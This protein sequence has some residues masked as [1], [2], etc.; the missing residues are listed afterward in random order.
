MYCI[1]KAAR[2]IQKQRSPDKRVHVIFFF[3]LRVVYLRR[4]NRP[5]TTDNVTIRITIIARCYAVFAVRKL[6]SLPQVCPFFI[7]FILSDKYVREFGGTRTTTYDGCLYNRFKNRRVSF[8]F[9]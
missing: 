9:F 3:L 2:R 7:I 6:L 5:E 1:G 8:F 4:H